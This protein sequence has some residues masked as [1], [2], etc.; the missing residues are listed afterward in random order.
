MTDDLR[1]KFAERRIARGREP[2][3]PYGAAPQHAS[4][5]KTGLV[6]VNATE[7]SRLASASFAG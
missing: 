1:A 2:L 4:A 7:S 3:E 5:A 6:K